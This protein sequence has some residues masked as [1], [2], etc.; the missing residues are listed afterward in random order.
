MN[1]A[2]LVG[3]ASTAKRSPLSQGY[4]F[5]DNDEYRLSTAVDQPAV[6]IPVEHDRSTAP[7]LVDV[8]IDCIEG[9]FEIGERRTDD[10]LDV[11]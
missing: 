1:A 9:E 6:L 11:L 5:D 10:Q 8:V 7:V 3:W 2:S 4:D